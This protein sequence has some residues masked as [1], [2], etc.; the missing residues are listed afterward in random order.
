MKKTAVIPGSFDPMTLGHA[1][2]V[3]RAL[4]VFDKVV[5]LVCVNFDKEYLFTTDERVFLAKETLS[6][7]DNVKVEEYSGWLWEWLEDHKP[8]VV[9]KGIRDEKDL[10]YERGMAE[11]NF[12]KSGV[13]T[14]FFV[15]D[16]ENGGISSTVV[17][18]RLESGEALDTLMS[19]NAQKLAQK[20]Y[21]Q[22][23]KK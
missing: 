18:Q 2:L 1:S 13:E 11:F 23:I 3:K 9:V 22:K 20:F 8:C 4:D 15:A 7:L 19:Q 17:R 14:L 16:E 5:V 21:T 10:L 12:E 6:D